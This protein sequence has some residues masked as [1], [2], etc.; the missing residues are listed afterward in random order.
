MVRKGFTLVE[1]MIVILIVAILA[2]VAIP[3]MSGKIDAAKWSEAKAALG[4]I[5]T[6]VRAYYAEKG[7]DSSVAA[8]TLD[9]SSSD[10][11][12]VTTKD[13]DGTYFSNKDYKGLDSA[14]CENGVVTATLIC[15]GGS[16]V[17]APK[18]KVTLTLQA[19]G[20]QVF[21]GPE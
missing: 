7:C 14:K 18:G 10:F 12:G 11:V 13:L 21:S 1:L 20:R 4:T 19:D 2:A 17:G 15:E 3:L 16:R 8:P 5:A 6:A 9:S